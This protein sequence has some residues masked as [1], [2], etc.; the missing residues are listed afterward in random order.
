MNRDEKEIRDL[1][2]RWHLATI[3]TLMADDALFLRGGQQPMTKADFAKNFR[4]MPADIQSTHEI[5]EIYVSGDLAYCYSHISVTMGGKKR[6]GPT[7]T[8]FR[9]VSGK[10][11]L[12]RDANMLA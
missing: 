6:E 5:K 8:V 3:L 9:K 4:A 11:V 7:F 2:D 1:I 12:S 10:W